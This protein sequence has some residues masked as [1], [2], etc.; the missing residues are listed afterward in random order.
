MEISRGNLQ[1]Q[2]APFRIFITPKIIQALSPIDSLDPKVFSLANGQAAFLLSGQTS[3]LEFVK[4]LTSYVAITT[5]VSKYFFRSPKPLAQLFTK[6]LTLSTMSCCPA[7]L[8]KLALYTIR[9]DA[10]IKMN[11]RKE[12]ALY[13]ISTIALGALMTPHFLKI[14]RKTYEF[15]PKGVAH[16]ALAQIVVYIA[17]AEVF[18][19][20]DRCI[21]E[22]IELLSSQWIESLMKY[23]D[24]GPKTKAIIDQK[25]NAAAEEINA[26]LAGKA[27]W[28][29]WMDTAPIEEDQISLPSAPDQMFATFVHNH[30]KTL[31]QHSIPDQIQWNKYFDQTGTSSVFP[32][33]LTDEYIPHITGDNLPFFH[34]YF[35]KTPFFFL[36]SEEQQATINDLFA[37]YRPDMVEARE[38]SFPDSEEQPQAQ[39]EQLQKPN[40]ASFSLILKHQ[41]YSH[42]TE[43]VPEEF[44]WS[45]MPF[46]QKCQM[47]AYFKELGLDPLPYW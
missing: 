43:H 36:L 37:K 20:N 33:P 12:R 6:Q 27:D 29:P 45:C 41:F 39:L 31:Q 10:Q 46:L 25:I 3:P 7:V 32:I 42:E 35:K 13:I 17:V 28:K 1:L 24:I 40:L 9:R 18:D 2:I 26:A 22:E 11:D 30:P 16:Y 4:L 5:L 34:K 38:G 47:N 14:H 8:V 44:K 23:K 19:W 21:A 15:C